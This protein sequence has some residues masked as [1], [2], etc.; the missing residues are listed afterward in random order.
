MEYSKNKIFMYLENEVGPGVFQSSVQQIY[1]LQKFHTAR[2]ESTN[3]QLLLV[4]AFGILPAVVFLE[5]WIGALQ[6]R[7]RFQTAFIA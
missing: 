5:L 4:F 3:N 1:N 2:T 7:S 6:V